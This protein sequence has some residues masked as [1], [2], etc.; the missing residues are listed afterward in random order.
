MESTFVIKVKYGDTLRRFSARVNG[1]E[2]L[3][4][5]MSGLRTK[6]IDL[7]SFPSD[8]ELTLTYIDE[9]GDV[10]SLV[11]DDDLRDVVRQCLKFLRIDVRL[12]S[13][14]SADSSVRMSRSSTPIMSPKVQG[15]LPSINTQG[16]TEILKSMPEPL[17]E[18]LS[19]VSL[20]FASRAASTSPV[21]ADLVECL[22]KIRQS[23]LIPDSQPQFGLN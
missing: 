17:L 8:S 7:F 18:V 11:D 10:V 16:V 20:D 2:Q 21:L 12:N 19:K 14:L 13:E 23:Y 22:S 3:D 15:P 4:L 5:D 1:N 6:V 9:D